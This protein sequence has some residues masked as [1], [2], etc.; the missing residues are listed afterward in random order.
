MEQVKRNN[1]HYKVVERRKNVDIVE[2][3]P[4]YS[5][6]HYVYHAYS[7]CGVLLY[8][9][10]GT[11]D[12]YLHCNSGTSQNKYLNEFYY[13]HGQGD[14]I[15]VKIIETF[16]SNTLALEL[17][18]KHILELKPLFNIQGSCIPK[19]FS[20]NTINETV[21]QYV[22]DTYSRDFIKLMKTYIEFFEDENSTE[23]KFLDSLTL[24]FKYILQALGV[25][26]IRQLKYN[27]TKVLNAYFLCV[28]VSSHSTM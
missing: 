1:K 5:G 3:S 7:K 12:R 19:V 18:K 22:R 6:I 4:D 24:A 10:K 26:K 20:N 25:D 27:K 16:S 21:L 15:T 23:I 9:G 13:T 8:V 14:C 28:S 2:Q 17:E 11:K